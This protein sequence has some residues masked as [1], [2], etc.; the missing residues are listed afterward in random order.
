MDGFDTDG[1]P[2]LSASVV[3]IPTATNIY[4]DAAGSEETRTIMHMEY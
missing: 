3:H 4:I 1:H 2:R